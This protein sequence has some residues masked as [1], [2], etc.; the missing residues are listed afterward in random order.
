M[1]TLFPHHEQFIL[2]T[3]SVLA[4]KAS[5]KR[6]TRA[7][8]HRPTPRRLSRRAVTAPL[9]DT[10]PAPAPHRAP[11]R[12]PYPL[13]TKDAFGE[14]VNPHEWG[15]RGQVHELVWQLERLPNTYESSVAY[16][17]AY[18]PRESGPALQFWL[19]PLSRAHLLNALLCRES[20]TLAQVQSDLD[21]Q[22]DKIYTYLPRWEVQYRM[23]RR[24]ATLIDGAG[25]SYPA[26]VETWERHTGHAVLRL[27]GYMHRVRA[28]YDKRA[29]LYRVP[30]TL[31]LTPEHL[32]PLDVAASLA[33]WTPAG[34]RRIL[35]P[36]L[37]SNAAVQLVSIDRFRTLCP[38]RHWVRTLPEALAAHNPCRCLFFDAHAGTCGLK[39]AVPDAGTAAW[40]CTDYEAL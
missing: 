36:D 39:N 28:R 9:F 12:A 16:I 3:P 7:R 31:G 5:R 35:A 32:I 15:T 8:S 2:A 40:A 6:V 34:L 30:E 14:F 18:R 1:L 20:R 25:D 27:D 17:R 33:N 23:A 13:D 38:D 4:S 11:E 21:V 29:G 24:E 19:A 22:I 37:R 26:H 10:H